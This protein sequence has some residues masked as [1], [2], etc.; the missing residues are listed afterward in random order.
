M[1]NPESALPHALAIF[2]LQHHNN[3][4][5]QVQF[6]LRSVARMH[7]PYT[8]YLNLLTA[9]VVSADL[10]GALDAASIRNR[11]TAVGAGEARAEGLTALRLG[12]N[13]CHIP[14]M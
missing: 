3:T 6:H 8:S 9:L 2:I 7:S 13:L 5:R 4:K 14:M 10:V 11:D 12:A 1:P